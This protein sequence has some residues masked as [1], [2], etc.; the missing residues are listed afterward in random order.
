M[1]K[2]NSTSRD[3]ENRAL[4]ANHANLVKFTSSDDSRL[5]QVLGSMR[6]LVNKALTWSGITGDV[7]QKD[8]S[9][10][11][12]PAG[13]R[14]LALDGGGVRGLFSILVLE[15]LM[16]AVREI[17]QP[18]SLDA[19]KPCQY[20]DIICGTSTGGLLA[21]MLGRLRMDIESCKQ[22]YR[23]LS[24]QIFQK[25]SWHFPG[26]VW[27]DA[28]MDKPWYS[29][30][31]LEGAVKQIVTQRLSLSEKEQLRARDVET[32]DAPLMPER[33]DGSKCFVCAIPDGNY[34][35]DR[36][37]TYIYRRCVPG[38]KATIWQAGRATSAAPLYFPSIE[39][40][41]QRYWDGGMHSNNPII[42]VVKEATQ[43]YP[44]RPFD[45]I[46]SIGTG[47]A[48]LVTPGGGLIHFLSSMVSRA[49]DTEAK[50]RQ[51]L[52]DFEGLRDVYFRLQEF[53]SLG[54]IDLADW[55]KLDEIE[56]L[57]RRYLDSIG[58]HDQIMRCA[59]QMAQNRQMAAAQ[60]QN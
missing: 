7:L 41:G 6:R 52:D 13:L 4:D 54:E 22:A 18:S 45:A 46:V 58:G 50:H 16:E 30:D 33:S 35:C 57:A 26:R 37:R 15:K 40:D 42:E 1:S 60:A 55:K 2:E 12:G 53:D 56:Q 24:A 9:L 21:I 27:W 3:A 17:D 8:A 38:P 20:F 11:Q 39:V 51:F 36:L 44:N 47:A 10:G 32:E 49:T 19:L 34:S 59:A 29:G 43:E 28:Y 5:H 25:S 48:E 23:S 31:A 14:V